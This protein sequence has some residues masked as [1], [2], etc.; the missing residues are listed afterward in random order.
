MATTPLLQASV[1]VVEQ[2]RK[3]F[4]MRNQY[5][6][7]DE[8]G[9]QI[10]SVEQSKQSVLAFVAR[11]GSD[12]DVWLPVSLEVADATGQPVLVM[13]KPWF[14]M[15]F[16]VSRLDGTR[17]GSIAKR[18]KL[19][20]ARFTITDPSGAEMGE[21]RAQNWRARDFTVTDH[22]GN[23]V[24]RA[25]KQW[26]GL[27]TEVFTDADTYVVNLLPQASEP[28]RSIALAASLAIDVLMKQKDY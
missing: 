10:G 15:T 18:I 8:A 11:F 25:T 23:E 5:R 13:G 1:L 16:S 4:E 12:L 19:G 7:F 22:A 3:L 20:K 28:L 24:A 17:L 14:R 27:A 9:T 26:R 2:T 6:I 21:I